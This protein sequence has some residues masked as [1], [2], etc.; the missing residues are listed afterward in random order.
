M[1][2]LI[3]G[4]QQET[5]ELT[6]QLEAATM[7]MEKYAEENDLLR[8]ENSDL[9]QKINNNFLANDNQ[10]QYGRKECAKIRNYPEAA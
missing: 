4:L 2:T 9:K 5:L 8:R 7:K 10:N 3:N 6:N 1:Q